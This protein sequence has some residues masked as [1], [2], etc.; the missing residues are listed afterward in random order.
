LAEVGHVEASRA[1]PIRS[2]L[3]GHLVALE[4]LGTLD[5]L[6]KSGHK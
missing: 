3:P 2:E 6:G 1:V 4:G 5:T